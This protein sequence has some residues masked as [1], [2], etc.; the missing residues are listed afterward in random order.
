MA[1]KLDPM[2]LKQ[3]IS[4]H[5]EGY[6]NRRI[7]KTLSFSHNINVYF[8]LIK[9]IDSSP[10]KGAFSSCKYNRQLPL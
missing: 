2:D 3:L 10:I 5:L 4:L 9:S 1:N 7:A 8:G 6:N